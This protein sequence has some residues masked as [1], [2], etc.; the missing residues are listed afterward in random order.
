M[1]ISRNCLS[2]LPKQNYCSKKLLSLLFNNSKSKILEIYG[3]ATF[4]SSPMF[5][6]TWKYASITNH[7]RQSPRAKNGARNR[8]ETCG[9]QHSTSEGHSAGWGEFSYTHSINFSQFKFKFQVY[10]LLQLPKIFIAGI[11]TS[12]ANR[13][14]NFFVRTVKQGDLMLANAP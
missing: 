8:E 6:A 7:Q 3:V 5:A 11:E 12:E 10:L 13:R 9:L 2:L 4:N 14:A 1:R